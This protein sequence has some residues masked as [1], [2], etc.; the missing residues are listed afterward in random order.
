MNLRRYY[1]DTKSMN[2]TYGIIWKILNT[3]DLALDLEKP[4]LE[5]LTAKRFKISENRFNHYLVM[6]QEADYVDGVEVV[7]NLADE[8]E[9]DYSDIRITLEGI[10][11]LIENSTMN[12][13]ATA[14]KE[15]G[16][17]VAEAGIT[18]LVDKIKT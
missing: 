14:A 8:F 16:L 1:S 7:A 12:K 5:Q 18:S 3:L 15:I 13:I 10:E 6:L 9:I 11:F 17:T 4:P 2:T